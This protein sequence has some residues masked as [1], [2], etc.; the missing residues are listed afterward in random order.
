MA[1]LRATKPNAKKSEKAQVL[2]LG[3]PGV[4]KTW[5]SIDFPNVLYIDC[6]GGAKRAEYQQKLEQAGAMVLTPED[7]AGD[8]KVVLEE[9]Q[10]L[11]MSD[12]EFKTLVIDSYSKLFNNTIAEEEERLLAANEKIAFGNEK[13]PAVKY[14][15]RLVRWLQKLDMN[16]ILICHEKAQWEGGEQIGHTYDGWDKLAYELDLTIRVTKTGNTRTGHVMKSRLSEFPDGST[17]DWN[18]DE[19]AR[20]YGRA[21][22]EGK[23]VALK[24]ATDEQLTQISVLLD[25][26]KVPNGWESKV[27]EKA[28]VDNWSEMDSDAVQKCIDY[29]SPKGTSK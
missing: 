15:R 12:H 5:L 16:V 8:F 28:G 23:V 18:Y 11:A 10:A 7:G 22:L 26:V 13:K 1:K 3:R 27:M 25:K 21:T 4:G 6:E 20:R 2:V 29:L 17:F 14:S 9:V 24:P 19:F